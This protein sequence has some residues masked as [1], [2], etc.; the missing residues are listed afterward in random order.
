ML[1]PPLFRNIH[2]LAQSPLVLTGGELHIYVHPIL[3]FS[4][5]AAPAGSWKQ[6][7]VDRKVLYIGWPWGRTTKNWIFL[8]KRSFGG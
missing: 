3:Q 7:G 1:G 5:R 2:I 8:T 4:G 6:L